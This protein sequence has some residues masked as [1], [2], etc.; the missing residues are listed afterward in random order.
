MGKREIILKSLLLQTAKQKTAT[1]NLQ[2]K[3]EKE[4][5]GNVCAPFFYKKNTAD[6]K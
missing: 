2:G 1:W 3:Q 4:K 6:T 5:G